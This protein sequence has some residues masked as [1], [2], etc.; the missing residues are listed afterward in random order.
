[1]EPQKGFQKIISRSIQQ[2]DI[3]SCVAMALTVTATASSRYSRLLLTPAAIMSMCS[4]FFSD[5]DCHSMQLSLEGKG[6]KLVL[7]YV[8]RQITV[9]P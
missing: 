4:N 3:R 1:M 5:Y 8:L 9:C 6:I 7:G 2:D